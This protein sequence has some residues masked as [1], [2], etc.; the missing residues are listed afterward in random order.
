MPAPHCAAMTAFFFVAPRQRGAA[1]IEFA[2]A[3]AMVLLLGLL[4]VEAARW[5]AVRHM[6]HVA[7]MEAARAGATAHGEP[8]RIRDAFLQGL[9]PLHASAQGEAGAWRQLTRVHAE[10]TASTGLTPWR[11]EVLRPDARAF[12]EHGRAGLNV[13]AAQ[14]RRAIDNDYQDLQHARRPPHPGGATI[15]DANTLALR[16][17]YLHKPWIA[18]VRAVLAT[19]GRNDASYAGVALQH[20]LLP[21]QIELE[22]EMHSHPVDWTGSG[23]YPAEIVA[24]A[25]RNARCH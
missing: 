17:T 9:L 7:L 16:L 10:H 3:G 4:G 5:Q 12:R 21:I 24:G 15:F 2:V 6:A 11:I 8:I 13:P 20:G 14:G 22:I 18:P 25:C 23:R 1:A 19:L